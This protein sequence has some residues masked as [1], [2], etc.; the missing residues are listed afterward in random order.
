M[1][2]APSD[3]K[4]NP[5]A[6]YGPGVS[7]VIVCVPGKQGMRPHVCSRTGTINI[8]Q[9]LGASSMGRVGRKWWMMHGDDHCPGVILVFDA[10]QR[11]G[12]KCYLPV[13]ERIRSTLAGDH[14]WIFK[15][16]T[17]ESQDAHKWGIKGE[18]NSRLDHRRAHEPPCIGGWRRSGR[19]EISQK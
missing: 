3:E 7:L 18:I 6:V 8:R 19:T 14:A 1:S 4:R 16:I 12:E 5:H 9:H 11:C 13:I 2:A 17:V 15:H 10:L